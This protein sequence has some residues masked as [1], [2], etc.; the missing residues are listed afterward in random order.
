MTPKIRLQSRLRCCKLSKDP[1][2]WHSKRR[3]RCLLAESTRSK[4]HFLSKVMSKHILKW[5]GCF[6][7]WL[8]WAGWI[9][10][11]NSKRRKHHLTNTPLSRS[12]RT[13]CWW[14]QTSCCTKRISCQSVRTRPSILNFQK[15][16]LNATIACLENFSHLQRNVNFRTTPATE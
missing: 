14:L 5:C 8:R 15:T 2:N 3:L 12:T 1:K 7:R 6:H 4:A 16:S 11:S 9:R 10:W 13:L